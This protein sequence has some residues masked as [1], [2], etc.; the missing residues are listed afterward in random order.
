[1]G[2]YLLYETHR[3]ESGHLG[4]LLEVV[5]AV[6]HIVDGHSTV[7]AIE[8]GVGQLRDTL[9]RAIPGLE[10]SVTILSSDLRREVS[11]GSEHT[12]RQSSS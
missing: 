9:V 4:G 12:G 2:L 11:G 6:L 8:A 5:Q 10:V 1:M 7:D 3:L